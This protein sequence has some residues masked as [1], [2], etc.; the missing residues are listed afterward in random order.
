ME[1]LNIKLQVPE[2][3]A[4]EVEKLAKKLINKELFLKSLEQCAKL[5]LQK[6]L[7]KSIASKSKLSEEKALELGELIKDDV[8]KEHKW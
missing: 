5:E 3:Y 6:Q 4:E 8:I 2:E 1:E 7:L